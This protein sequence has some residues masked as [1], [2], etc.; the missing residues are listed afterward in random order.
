MYLFDVHTLSFGTSDNPDLGILVVR[1]PLRVPTDDI[2]G[3]TI[4][5]EPEML[6]FWDLLKER[7]FE[8]QTVK[9][10][11]PNEFVMKTPAG[12]E[13]KLVPMTLAIYKDRVLPKLDANPD[14][15]T[16]TQLRAHFLEDIDASESPPT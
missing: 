10:D 6:A 2:E 3:N 5:G 12:D 14:I 1:N 8:I 11:K 4:P 16:E 15:R 13:I 9:T 7:S